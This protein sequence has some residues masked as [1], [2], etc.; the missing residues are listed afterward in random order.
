MRTTLVNYFDNRKT[1]QHALKCN[2]KLS[3]FF[4]TGDFEGLYFYPRINYIL[5]VLSPVTVFICPSKKL[6]Q[7]YE[8]IDLLVFMSKYY[9]SKTLTAS[10]GR[11]TV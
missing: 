4:P 7:E 9:M 2:S 6:F 1:N 3:V 11:T 8:N 10:T 5:R